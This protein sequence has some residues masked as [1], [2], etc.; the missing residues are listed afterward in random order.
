MQFFDQ[1]A[2]QCARWADR[3]VVVA[4]AQ[5]ALF[6]G[7]RTVRHIPNAVT[8]RPT[9]RTS[10]PPSGASGQPIVLFV[11]RL[12]PEKG[13]DVLM[14]AL[15]SLLARHPSV[16]VRLVGDGPSRPVVQQLIDELGVGPHV[17]LIGHVED[18]TP[19]YA[20]ARVLCL[21]SRS[22]GMPN[23]I[24]E[25]V[26]A[27]LPVVATDVGDVKALV[28]AELGRV[29]GADDVAA[30]AT[31]LGDEVAHDRGLEFLRAREQLLQR[32]DRATRAR[33]HRAL[34]DEI[35]AIS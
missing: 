12:S 23:V 29:V 33:A 31:A 26:A 19:Q 6:N 10:V 28:S 16:R 34:Y 7:R 20:T 5:R 13:V 11:G 27:G 32:F 18:T 30:L 24:L 9:E 25:A 17:E 21:P 2:V 8:V 15:P 35:V 14:R 3:I 4:A 1:L 22:E